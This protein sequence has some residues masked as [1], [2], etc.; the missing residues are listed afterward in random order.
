MA[1]ME[2]RKTIREERR[3]CAREE[4]RKE[5][6]ADISSINNENL[7]DRKRKQTGWKEKKENRRAGRRKGEVV[8]SL[9][10]LKNAASSPLLA[11]A[12]PPLSQT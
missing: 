8:S 11:S 2:E 3:H 10:Y 12:E 7:S 9:L 5:G 1:G 6:N 4:G